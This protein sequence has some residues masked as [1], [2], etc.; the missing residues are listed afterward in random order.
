MARPVLFP[1]TTRPDIDD[2]AVIVRD[3]S[4][5]RADKRTRDNLNSITAPGIEVS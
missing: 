2:A 1:T 3:D 5:T 4:A